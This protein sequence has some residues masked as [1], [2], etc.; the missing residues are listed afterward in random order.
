MAE[1]SNPE[2]SRCGE[3]ALKELRTLV[4]MARVHP[5]AGQWSAFYA[6]LCRL[7][8]LYRESES[9]AG[10]FVRRLEGEMECLF[11]FLVEEGVE[12]TNNLAERTLRFGVLWRKRSQGTRSDTSGFC[13][14]AILVGSNASPPSMSLWMRSLLISRDKNLTLNS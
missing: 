14:C 12:P 5:S 13:P 8:A 2:L 3:W 1:S 7:I 11:T 10:K 6:R 4:H 9:E